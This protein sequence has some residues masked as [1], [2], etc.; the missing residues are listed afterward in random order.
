MTH[1]TKGRSTLRS[2]VH[3]SR[4]N[5]TRGKA[6][7]AGSGLVLLSSTAA[8]ALSVVLAPGASLPVPATTAAT[9]PTLDGTVI[10]DV[11][12]PFTINGANGA[13]LCSGKLQDRV[14]QSTKT[15]QYDFY[16]AIRETAGTGEVNRMLTSSFAAQPLRVAYRTDGLG[17][18]PPRT[19]ARNAAPG[20]AVEFLLTDPPV[21]CARHEESRF[22]LLRT[23]VKVFKPGGKTEIFATTGNSASIPTVMP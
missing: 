13:V 17:T 1:A 21:S 20:A 16:F 6:C 19:A 9:E 5:L 14:V 12:V 23:D 18:V 8:L 22:M 3:P 15:G 11:M 7:L 10:H 2:S 4:M